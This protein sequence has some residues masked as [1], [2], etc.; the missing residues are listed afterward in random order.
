MKTG[1]I[2][3]EPVSLVKVFRLFRLELICFGVQ[4]VD[5]VG[6]CTTSYLLAGSACLWCLVYFGWGNVHYSATKKHSVW[7]SQRIFVKKM[8]QSWWTYIYI[9]I[10]KDTNEKVHCEDVQGINF[11]NHHIWTIGSSRSPKYSSS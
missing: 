4:S 1:F 9:Y 8:C 2:L 6:R 7:L 11:W 5:T 3:R 10:S